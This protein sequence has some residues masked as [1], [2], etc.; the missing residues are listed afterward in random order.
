VTNQGDSTV[1]VIATAT[2]VVSAPVTVGKYPFGV[3]ITP[4]GEHAYVANPGDGTVSVIATA[5]GVVSAPVT[6]G[7][8]PFGVA[9]TRACK[10]A[11]DTVRSETQA[12]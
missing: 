6:V 7:K 3:A 8:Y 12:K 1:S 11:T 9:I 10:H 4:D 5:T 2:G